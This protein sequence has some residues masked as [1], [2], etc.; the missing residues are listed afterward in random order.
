[1]TATSAANLRLLIG[2][3]V[4]LVLVACSSGEAGAPR[5]TETTAIVASPT[6]LPP[7]PTPAPT[8]I[9]E[10]TSFANAG[11]DLIETAF[12]ALMDH[13]IRVLSPATILQPAFRDALA[14]ARRLGVDTS[15]LAFVAS[16]DR[17][18]AWGAFADAYTSLA[19]RLAAEQTASVRFAALSGMTRALS[20]CHTFFLPPIRTEQLTDIRTGRG[21]VGV[22]LEFAPVRPSYVREVTTGGPADVAGVKPG[23][24]LLALDGSDMTQ[25]GVEVINDLLRGDEGSRVRLDLRRPANGQAYSVELS[26]ARVVPPA[27]EGKVLDDGI[28]YLR[29]RTFTSGG[30]VREALDAIVG[31]FETAGVGAWVLDLRDNPGGERDLRLIGRF[32][33]DQMVERTLLREG[34]LEVKHGEGEPYPDRPLAV[35]VNGGTASVSEIFAAALQ[36]Y[37]RARIFGTGTARCAGFVWLVRLD[38][39]STVGV[40]IAHSLTPL[41]ERPLYQTGVIPQE[42]VRQSADDLAF[43][44]DPVLERAIAWLKALEP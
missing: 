24:V 4:G 32:L 8:A 38:D 40:T 3:L 18:E 9:P 35:L 28:G 43:G 16:Q 19:E 21:S 5:P 22:G 13:Y 7:T 36:D 44:R 27:A 30:A 31:S 6:A 17:D 11:L 41:T 39:G 26:R 33:G 42:T 14:E 12:A 10:P 2:I 34:Q 20:D 23:D 37:G 1:M 15:G 25:A 29:V